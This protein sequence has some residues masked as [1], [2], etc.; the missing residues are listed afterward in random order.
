MEKNKVL[1][2]CSRKLCHIMWKVWTD[3]K[4]FDQE[5]AKERLL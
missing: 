4:E 5:V 1:I 2:A 3:N